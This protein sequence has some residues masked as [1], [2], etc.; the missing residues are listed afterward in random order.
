[1]KPKN[2]A[3]E[4]ETNLSEAMGAASVDKEAG[5]IKNV[6]ILTGDKVSKNKTL[7]TKKVLQEAVARYEGAKMFLDHPKN[8]ETVRSVHDFGGTYKNVRLEEGR[9]LRADLHLINKT[10]IRDTV[11]PIAES[12]AAGVGLS[13]RDRGHGKEE[14][15]VFLVEGFAGKGP[16]SIDLVME[17]SVNETLFES[18]QGGNDD[19]DTKEILAKLTLAE[20]TEGAPAL[21]EAIRTEARSA[22]AKELDAE[23]K[24]GKDAVATLGKARKLTLLAES[25]LAA[26]VMAKLKPLIEAEAVTFESATAMLTAQK[27]IIE[28]MKPKGKEPK[29]TGHGASKDEHLEEAELPSD[30]DAVRALQG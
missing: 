3:I 15:G 1:M 30:D 7:Y 2:H 10:S 6:L 23:I 17:A 20:L 26:E 19:M 22:L 24:A 28:A 21:V 16:F 25:G 18:N 9:L 14:N 29:V 8:G 13:I 5:V 11:I 27:E 12:K 4:L